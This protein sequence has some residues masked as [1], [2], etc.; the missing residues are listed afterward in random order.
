MVI[1]ISRKQCVCLLVYVLFSVLSNIFHSYRGLYIVREEVLN[2]YFY[3]KWIEKKLTL[4]KKYQNQRLI[5]IS[6][7]T[8]IYLINDLS[9]AIWLKFRWNGLH[10]LNINQRF[11]LRI[12]DNLN[13]F[14][15]CFKTSLLLKDQL[16]S[17]WIPG[18]PT[19][20]PFSFSISWCT[21]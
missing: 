6:A 19:A 17:K 13:L 2:T 1:Y 21:V 10:H 18:K 20:T 9:A 11:N 3:Q 14:L 7:E 4:N 15:W 16:I 5:C 12:F 8:C